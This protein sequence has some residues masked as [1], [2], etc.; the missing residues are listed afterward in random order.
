MLDP[1]IILGGQPVK[2]EN[3]MNALANAEALRSARNQ[4]QLHDLALQD[5]QTQLN[6]KNALTSALK[7]NFDATTGKI[8]DNGV[9]NALANS[10]K[11][12][13]IDGYQKQVLANKKAGFDADKVQQ[14]GFM[15][16][17]KVAHGRLEAIGGVM[18]SLAGVQGVTHDQITNGIQ[19]LV[20]IGMVQPDMAQKVV[21][22]IPADP[23]MLP[24][25]I[26]QQQQLAVSAKDQVDFALRKQIAD[27][28]NKTQ[29]T[30]TGM[31]NKT[32]L[33]NTKLNNGVTMRGQDLVDKREKEALEVKRAGTGKDSVQ[34]L[35]DAKSVL[36]LLD[37]AAPL[38]DKATNSAAGRAVDIARGAFGGSSPSADAAAQL[39]ALEG[40][41]VAKMPKMSGPQSDKDVAMYKQMAGRI[42]DPMMPASQKKAAMATIREIN[43]RYINENGGQASSAP[44][45]AGFK[46]EKVK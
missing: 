23:A 2:L 24:G 30:T 46:I 27:D 17:Q 40:A 11:G 14:E 36:S 8:D 21:A 22:S 13:L 39:Q 37:Q 42:G 1:N 45:P 31:N 12:H 18:G 9:V 19:H 16:A 44:L 34:K 26:K 7:A 32:S 10:G 20:D 29:I 43:Q 15:E 38:L 35:A 3:P 33:L 5:R 25:W 4:N 28:S 41:L 6:D